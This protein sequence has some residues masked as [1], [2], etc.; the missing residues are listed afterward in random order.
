MVII[1]QWEVSNAYA[2]DYQI[3]EDTRLSGRQICVAKGNNKF[4]LVAY[5]LNSIL[6]S[7][8]DKIITSFD[9]TK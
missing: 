5:P 4:I 1:L 3:K 8:F 7:D 2:T 6:L 9:F